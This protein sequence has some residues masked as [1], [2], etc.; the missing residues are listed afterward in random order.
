[1]SADLWPCR[2]GAPGVLNLGTLGYCTAHVSE[3]LRSFDPSVF[4]LSGCWVQVG[5]LRPDHGPGWAECECPGCGATA[6]A[7]VG[8]ACAYCEHTR[9]RLGAWQ[10]DRVLTPPEIDEHDTRRPA[11]MRAWVERL[12]V[13]VRAGIVEEAEARRAIRGQGVSDVAA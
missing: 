12:A 6:V 5:C 3:L 9:R 8:S 11:A 7:L 13:A 1:M 2:C 10:A 4:A